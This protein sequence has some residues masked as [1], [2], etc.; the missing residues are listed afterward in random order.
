L[1]MDGTDSKGIFGMR[2]VGAPGEDRRGDIAVIKDP[3]DLLRDK[4]KIIAKSEESEKGRWNHG[5]SKQGRKGS[6]QK[7]KVERGGNFLNCMEK[8]SQYG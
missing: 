5:R 3:V 6:S 1:G 4:R 8:G 2:K 7:R